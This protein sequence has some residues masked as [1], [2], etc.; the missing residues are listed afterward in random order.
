M[1]INLSDILLQYAPTPRKG[2]RNGFIRFN[3]PCCV[4]AGES[5]PDSKY[6]AGI[7][8]SGSSVFFHCF[9]CKTCAGWEPGETISKYMEF[10]LI[11][12]GVSYDDISLLKI[13]ATKIA[14]TFKENDEIIQE[15]SNFNP[16][17]KQIQLPLGSAPFSDWTE[18]EDI[19]EDFL[20]CVNYLYNERGEEIFTSYNY[21]WTPNT[22]KKYNR[23]IIIPFYFNSKIV[24]YSGR[25]IDSITNDNTK[26]HSSIP[27]HYL[28]NNA[29]FDSNRKYVIIVEGPFDAIAIDGVAVLGK[30]L[31]K[32]QIQWINKSGKIIVILPDRDPSKNSLIDYAIENNWTISYPWKHGKSSFFWD[33]NIKDAADAVKT[34]GKIFAIKSIIHNIIDNTFEM[35]I[36]KRK[37][38]LEEKEKL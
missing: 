36:L 6:R 12:F 25:T 29:V 5:R 23:R 31:S 32:E 33:L 34:Y 26:Y 1:D 35:Q 14:T 24:G 11:N 18:H 4:A 9:N 22:K 16:E 21:Y 7:K 30:S 8:L 28:F 38:T 2:C 3:C 27:Q 15:F 13:H 10:V 17:Y 20:D 37:M 19:P